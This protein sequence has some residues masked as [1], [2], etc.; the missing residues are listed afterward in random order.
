MI[1]PDP[2]FS[3]RSNHAKFNTKPVMENFRYASYTSTEWMSQACLVRLF[4]EG[5][6]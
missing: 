1:E 4:G 3:S 6:R 5:K 2:M